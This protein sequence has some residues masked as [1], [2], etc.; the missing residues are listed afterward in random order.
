MRRRGRA[1]TGGKQEEEWRERVE[2]DSEG[3]NETE[4]VNEK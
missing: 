1:R 2:R 4:N 3:E